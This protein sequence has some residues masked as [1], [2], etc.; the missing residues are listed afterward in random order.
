M[1]PTATLAHIR[2]LASLLTPL[3]LEF[4]RDGCVVDPLG[5]AQR[6]SSLGRAVFRYARAHLH[7][8]E[9]PSE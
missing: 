6:P 9:R 7:E 4:L 3:Q 8:L 2:Q 5:F 1:T